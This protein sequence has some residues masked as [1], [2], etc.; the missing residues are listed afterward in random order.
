MRLPVI[1]HPA[2]LKFRLLFGW[3]VACSF[4]GFPKGEGGERGRL[5]LDFCDIPLFI[6]FSSN[7]SS[8]IHER[9]EKKA[10]LNM[11]NKTRRISWPVPS[12]R[13]CLSLVCSSPL[14][15]HQAGL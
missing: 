1:N 14:F 9:G 6:F 10:V 11:E 8:V 3:L 15:H 4:F 12:G 7:F 5:F 13:V 2:E